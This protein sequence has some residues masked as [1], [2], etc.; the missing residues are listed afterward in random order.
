[1]ILK[2]FVLTSFLCTVVLLSIALIP[3]NYLN[4]S[5]PDS[6]NLPITIP[7]LEDIVKQQP[8]QEMHQTQNEYQ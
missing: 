7:F 1:M 4:N 8:N 5:T 3:N 2:R 6:K